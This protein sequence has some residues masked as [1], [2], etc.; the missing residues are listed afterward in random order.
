MN[1]VGIQK[2]SFNEQ[3]EVTDEWQ[4]QV[5]QQLEDERLINEVFLHG[6]HSFKSIDQDSATLTQNLQDD[7]N[8]QYYDID[9]AFTV[10]TEADIKLAKKY[11]R[12]PLVMTVLAIDGNKYTIGEKDY[13]VMLLTENRYDGRNTREMACSVHFQS[14]KAIL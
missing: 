2:I 7:E 6:G 14:S 13:P 4:Q 3:N 5:E 12:R 1:K 8:G 10:R 11:E 9:L